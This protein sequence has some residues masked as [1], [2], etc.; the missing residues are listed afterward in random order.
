MQ[1]QPYDHIPDFERRLDELI[2]AAL[3]IKADPWRV[4]AVLDIRA[5]R[6][7]MKACAMREADRAKSEPMVS[8]P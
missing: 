7:R 2:S 3:A 6:T 4:T 1:P 8:Q 5:D